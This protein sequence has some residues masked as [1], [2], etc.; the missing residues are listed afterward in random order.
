MDFTSGGSKKFAAITGKLSQQQYPNNRFAIALDNQVVSAPTVS[1]TLSGSAEISGNFN[2]TTAQDLANVL[3]YGALPL[4]FQEQ[5]VTTVTAALGAD[6]LHAGLHRRC[7]RPRA[8]HHLPGGLLPRPRARSPSS[9]SSS[10]R[11]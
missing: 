6:Q 2:Q 5:S 3:S 9:A 11:S 10:R 8:G 1:S 4:S 7:H